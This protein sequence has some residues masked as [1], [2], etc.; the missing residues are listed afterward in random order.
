MIIRLPDGSTVPTPL[1]IV[2]PVAFDEFHDSVVDWPF[3][4]ADG[5]A[6]SEI[7]GAGGGS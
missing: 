3:S 7:V 6:L 1:S 2:T 4:I 5:E